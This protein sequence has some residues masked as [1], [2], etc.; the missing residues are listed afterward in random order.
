MAEEFAFQAIGCE[1]QG[2]DLYRDVL[3]HCAT[4]ITSGGVVW[5]TIRPQA[6]LRFGLALPLRFL[7]SIHRLT[8]TGEAS[9]LAAHYPSCGGTPGPGLWEAFRS[10]VEKHRAR[11][12]SELTMGVQTNEV[13]RSAALFPGI[14]TVAARTG[15]PV[16]LR[17]VG[18]SAGLNLRLD[19]Y[20]YV[21]GSWTAGDPTGAVV[22]ADRWGNGVP[23]IS[24]PTIVDRAG[25]DPEPIDPTTDEGATKLLGFIWPDQLDRRERTI[26]AIELARHLPARVERANADQWLEAELDNATPGVATVVMHSIVWQYIDKVERQR[27]TETIERFGAAATPARPLAWLRFEPH[28]PDRVHAGLTLRLWDGVAAHGETELLAESGYHGQWVRWHAA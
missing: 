1:G 19:R 7:A 3:N 4:D 24:E 25:C 11:I 6:K 23:I 15:L 9:D 10:T 26:A 8:L 14:A 12:T 22:I 16:S 18:T 2:S 21:E 27:I 13:V 20:R 28:E 5:E 17:E